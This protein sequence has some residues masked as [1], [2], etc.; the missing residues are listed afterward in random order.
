MGDNQKKV[1]FLRNERAMAKQNVESLLK[2]KQSIKDKIYDFMD[3]LDNKGAPIPEKLKLEREI[4]ERKFN[5]ENAKE[6]IHT[7]TR[8]TSRKLG[9]H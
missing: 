1:D 6:I 8:R 3:N 7:T 4:T 5:S 2:Q 9:A